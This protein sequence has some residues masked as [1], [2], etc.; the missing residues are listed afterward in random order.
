MNPG[1]SPMNNFN[2]TTSS[3][4]LQKIKGEVQTSSIW[5]NSDQI[6]ALQILKSTLQQAEHGKKILGYVQ[7]NSIDQSILKPL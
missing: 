3:E 4:V 7:V 1:S 6:A 2:P 5:F